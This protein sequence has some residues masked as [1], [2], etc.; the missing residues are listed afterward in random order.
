MIELKRDLGDFI[1]TLNRFNTLIS[2]VSFLLTCKTLSHFRYLM[3][4]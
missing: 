4:I 1:L 2:L 3:T